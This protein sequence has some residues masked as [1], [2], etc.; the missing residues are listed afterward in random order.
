MSFTRSVFDCSVN[1]LGRLF[2]DCEVDEL[3][4]NVLKNRYNAYLNIIVEM[5]DILMS[6]SL[7]LLT[8]LTLAQW[9]S[10]SQHQID[11]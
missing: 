1:M 7:N 4:L 2:G 11:Y 9:D 6:L 10:S 5:H 3:T 8:S